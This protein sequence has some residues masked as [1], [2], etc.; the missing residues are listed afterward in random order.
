[1]SQPAATDDAPP[2]EAP[3][4]PRCPA[5][6]RGHTWALCE[7]CQQAI[8]REL[9]ELLDL[10]ALASH[11][12]AL[13]PATRAGAPTGGSRDLP[14]PV[15]L[16]ALDLAIGASLLA[17]MTADDMGLVDWAD[18][19]REL[20]G[21]SEQPHGPTRTATLS[22]AVRY[23][24]AQ[25][26]LAGRAPADGGHPAIDEFAADIH[27]AHR[28]ALAALRL[29]PADLDPS[30]PEPPAFT[31]A[32]PADHPTR[33]G[34]CGNRLGVSRQPLPLDDQR[35]LPVTLNCDRCG[36]HWDGARLLVVAKAAGVP[37]DMSE[38]EACVWWDTTPRGLAVLVR[39]GRATRR[40]ADRYGLPDTP[41]SAADA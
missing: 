41:R 20:F 2:V 6:R 32:C 28:R 15:A 27:R 37:I 22:Q 9:A 7:G 21:H 38:A 19:W 36:T 10:H 30:Q 31:I 4:A 23:L 25:L 11:P 13:R 14:T 3:P 26:A 29:T 24:R 1:M 5:C 16:D 35:P 33:D 39:A 8:S 17:G 40:G 34:L 18:D 12:A